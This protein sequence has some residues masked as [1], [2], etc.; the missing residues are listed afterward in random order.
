MLGSIGDRRLVSTLPAEV[1]SIR[2]AVYLSGE[3]VRYECVATTNA[4]ADDK[5]Y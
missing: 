4:N 2:R 1:V 3:R 5:K